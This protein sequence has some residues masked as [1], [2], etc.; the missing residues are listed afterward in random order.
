MSKV[1]RA[2][3]ELKLAANTKLT[4][5][6]LSL[7]ILNNDGTEIVADLW[8]SLALDTTT[9]ASFVYYTSVSDISVDA[10]HQTSTTN[11]RLAILYNCTTGSGG[12]SANVDQ[13][14]DTI[15]IGI[16]YTPAS[17]GTT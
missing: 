13:R 8:G 17:S 10:S 3:G 5:H 9:Q 14:I 6:T 7:L 11:V 2:S 12:G 1:G 16:T 15:R 4:G